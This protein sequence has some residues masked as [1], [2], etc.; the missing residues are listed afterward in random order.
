MQVSQCYKI[1]SRVC[2][3]SLV[4]RVAG[5][6]P[7][8]NL[9]SLTCLASTVSAWHIWKTKN[10]L[11]LQAKWEMGVIITIHGCVKKIYFNIETENVVILDREEEWFRGGVKE[12]IWLWMQRYICKVSSSIWQ[13]FIQLTLIN[14]RS[15]SINLKCEQCMA[16]QHIMGG[17][18]QTTQFGILLFSP[19][20]VTNND[21][22]GASHKWFKVCK[23]W[24]FGHF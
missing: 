14:R 4:Y 11:V 16:S 3:E 17:A 2:T 12:A 20:L 5:S 22:W 10:I 18:K 21:L 19:S 13:N 6:A 9:S 7:Y 1:A 15:T 24:H 8:M 23:S